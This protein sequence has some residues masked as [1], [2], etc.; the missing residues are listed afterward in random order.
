MSEKVVGFYEKGLPRCI[1]LAKGKDGRIMTWRVYKDMF[2]EVKL[3]PVV[4]LEW[5]EELIKDEQEFLCSFK[6]E[7]GELRAYHKGQYEILGW[8]LSKAKK[9][10]KRE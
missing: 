7:K 1:D 10:A 4:T 3:V 2:P 5:L 9:E 8:V 6:H